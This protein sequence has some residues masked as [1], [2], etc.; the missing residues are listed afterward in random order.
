MSRSVSCRG[1][2]SLERLRQ[3]GA[4]ALQNRPVG[5]SMLRLRWLPKQ[6]RHPGQGTR[7]STSRQDPALPSC[8]TTHCCQTHLPLD[9]RLPEGQGKES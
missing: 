8:D 5:V 4:A 3:V 9:L 6:V 2:R 7:L 1:H